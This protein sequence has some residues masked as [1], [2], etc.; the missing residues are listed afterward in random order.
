MGRHGEGYHNVAES[1]YG[2]PAWDV[3]IR[4]TINEKEH[5]LIGTDSVLLE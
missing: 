2:T 3:R 4:D 5:R 1:F